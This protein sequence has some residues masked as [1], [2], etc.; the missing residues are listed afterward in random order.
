MEGFNI[1]SNDQDGREPCS[2][3]RLCACEIGGSERE[4]P[5]QPDTPIARLLHNSITLCSRL[6][7]YVV[8]TLGS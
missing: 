6:H 4:G 7:K 2:T 5:S 1:L 8:H 3:N